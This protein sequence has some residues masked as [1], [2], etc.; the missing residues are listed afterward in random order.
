MQQQLP[1][2]GLPHIYSSDSNSWSYR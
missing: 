1:Q 2:T